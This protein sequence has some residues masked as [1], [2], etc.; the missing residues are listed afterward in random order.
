MPK[1]LHLRA[2]GQL[3]GAERVV[4]ELADLLPK[5]GYEP[6]IGVPVEM[7]KSEPELIGSARQQGSSVVTFPIKHAFDLGIARNIRQFVRENDIE[8]IHSHGYRE[9]LY[10]LM[11]RTQ[12]KLIATN[13]LWKRTTLKLKLYACMDAIL[14][15][16]FHAV[17]AVSRPVKT[18][19]QNAGISN[20]KLSIVAN[21]INTSL[22]SSPVSR[23]TALRSFDIPVD[24]VVVGTL[25][26]LTAEK[27]ID[28]LLNALPK[29]LQNAPNIHCL[30][31]GSGEQRANLESL[32]HKL[33]IAGKV[34]FGGRQS[35]INRVLSAM[36]IFALPSLNE[37]LPMALLEAMAAGKAIVATDVGDVGTAIGNEAGKLIPP[38]SSDELSQAIINLATNKEVRKKLADSAR[39]AVNKHFSSE[40][41][42]A[43]YV[44]LYNSLLG[45]QR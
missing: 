40:S 1:V 42:T 24:S 16:F 10:A 32:V 9:D 36:D 30:I 12:A 17:V 5:H 7:H 2:T 15:K 33:N 8:I 45:S 21:G 23:D 11:A 22:Y 38:A 31:V 27:G 28:Y 14:L 26:S 34:T 29:I 43:S 6:F 20:N 25:S 4:L 3:L 39:T 44:D 41:M 35:D 13:H 18:D 19:M 37:G